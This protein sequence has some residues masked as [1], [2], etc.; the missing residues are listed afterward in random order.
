MLKNKLLYIFVFTQ[1]IFAQ[2]LQEMQKL[3]SEYDKLKKQSTLPIP[4]STISTGNQNINNNPDMVNIVPL[5]LGMQNDSIDNF[6]KYFGYDFFTKRDTVG[7]W[8]NLSIPNNYVLGPGDE[9]VISLWGETSLRQTYTISR[10][11][12]IYDEKVG[13]LNVSGKTIDQVNEYI[14]NQFGRVYSTLNGSNPSTFLDIS[15]G[16]LKSINV[17]FVGEVNYPGVYAIHP[18]SNVITGLIQAGGVDTTG[19]LRE[20]KIKRNNR[21]HIK[22]DLYDFLLKGNISDEIQLKDKDIVLIDFRRSTIHVDSSV[23]KP[24]IYES[25]KGETLKDLIDFAG[26]LKPDAGTKISLKR[27]VPH[28]LRNNKSLNNQSIY[29]PYSRSDEIL[30]QNGDIITVNKMLESIQSVEM[31]GQVKSPGVYNYYKDMNLYDLI[32]LGGGFNDSTFWKS[33]YNN[34]AEIVRRDP[35]SRYEK[36]IKINLNRILDE[37]YLKSV[38]LQNLDRFVVHSNLN[39]FEKKNIQINGEVNIPGSYPLVRDNENLNDLIIRAGGL[40]NKALKNGIAIYRSRGFFENRKEI[41]LEI[42]ELKTIQPQNLQKN[43]KVRVAWKSNKISLMPGDSIIIKEKTGTI[44][45]SGEVYNPGLIEFSK[46]R[47]IRSYIN[48]AGGLTELGNKRGIVIVYANGVVVPKKWYNSPK[49]TDG[50]TI[51]INKKEQYEPF[52]ITQFA[53]NWTQILSSLITAVILSQQIGS[54]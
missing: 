54:N 40:T 45:V 27:I 12:K 38:K 3:K 51:V 19:S 16:S 11:G 33:V 13:V 4:Q 37:K 30:V 47:S 46:G 7:F 25:I 15:L 29:V 48:A 53:T 52:N 41:N 44:N 24:G 6:K 9:L 5:N 26:G 20:I 43:D 42:E 31:I 36:I 18:F 1:I 28:S 49:V 22:I 32:E 35:S 8:E 10:S 39:F 50:S 14:L 21:L 17:N 34:Q 23:F 2:S